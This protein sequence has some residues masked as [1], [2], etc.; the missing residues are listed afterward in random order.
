MKDCK[1]ANKQVS[2]MT[3]ELAK[4]SQ[5]SNVGPLTD[6]QAEMEQ[7]KSDVESNLKELMALLQEMA[8]EWG[9]M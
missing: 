9:A 8:E 5:V 4:I 1:W 7:E 3:A 6:K 2:E